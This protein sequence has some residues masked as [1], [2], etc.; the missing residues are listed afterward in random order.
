MGYGKSH[1]LEASPK[2]AM[3]IRIS[4][5]M[6]ASGF[7]VTFLVLAAATFTAAACSARLS[8]ALFRPEPQIELMWISITR[9]EGH[10][11]VPEGAI[12]NVTRRRI[13]VERCVSAAC[14]CCAKIP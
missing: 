2:N 7:A 9:K 11:L 6:F 5:D 14:T 1:C 10:S 4:S 8:I 3:S 12:A 13:Y